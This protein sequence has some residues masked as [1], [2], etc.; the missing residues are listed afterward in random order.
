METH[1]AVPLQH[2]GH[3][4]HEQRSGSASSE[5]PWSTG[6][7]RWR[8]DSCTSSRVGWYSWSARLFY[9]GRNGGPAPRR[10]LSGSLAT[11][12]SAS[13]CRRGRRRAPSEN[14][15][16]PSVLHR[17]DARAAEF[18]AI[19][20]VLPRPTEIYP[21]RSSFA[22]FP[23]QIGNWHGHRQSLDGVYTDV[24]KLD[25]YVLADFVDGSGNVANFYIACYN[26]QRKGEAVHSPRSCLPGG[27]WQMREFRP[28]G[29]ARVTVDGRPLRVNRT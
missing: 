1:R 14:T 11:G 22:E 13:N 21:Q 8:R 6:E 4:D 17:R 3:G 7:S 12:I 9:A 5:S 20:F 19:T 18:I 26:S 23:M 2:P 28:A 25:D 15:P 24:L 29:P 16:I 10:P 27:G